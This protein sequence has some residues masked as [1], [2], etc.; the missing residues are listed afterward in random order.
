MSLACLGYIM[1]QEAAAR[2]AGA[3]SSDQRT[4]TCFSKLLCERQS[5]T[6]LSCCAVALHLTSEG[7][8][9]RWPVLSPDGPPS[10]SAQL[11]RSF[12]TGWKVPFPVPAAEPLAPGQHWRFS[13]DKDLGPNPRACHARQRP[14]GPENES[15]FPTEP[16]PGYPG[17]KSYWAET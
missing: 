15:F 13:H 7:H 14:W 4:E 12:A 11:S 2:G 9:R 10:C 16:M 3:W 8:F 17:G 1:G 6:H 5:T